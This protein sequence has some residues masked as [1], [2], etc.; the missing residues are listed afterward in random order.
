[1]ETRKVSR[2]KQMAWSEWKQKQENFRNPRAAGQ[3]K[4]TQ[5]SVKTLIALENCFI[6]NNEIMPYALDHNFL[7]LL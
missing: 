3:E 1:M 6:A 5:D 7:N 4:K 2:R